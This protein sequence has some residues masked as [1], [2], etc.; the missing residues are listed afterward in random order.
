MLYVLNKSTNDVLPISSNPANST[1]CTILQA[2]CAS[3]SNPNKFLPAIVGLGQN[4]RELVDATPMYPSPAGHF[5][6]TDAASIISIGITS[7]NTAINDLVTRAHEQMK[8][9][10]F[11]GN[12]Y[13]RVQLVYSGDRNDSDPSIIRQRISMIAER[14]HINNTLDAAVN[15]IQGK[16]VEI[17]SSALQFPSAYYA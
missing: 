1:K 3:I 10:F 16:P 7:Q 12:E 2:A 4:R 15:L 6:D 9:K 8:A 11:Q 17:G 14:D 5:L 13:L